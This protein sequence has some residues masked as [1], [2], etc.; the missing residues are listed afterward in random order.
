MFLK[1]SRYYGIDTVIAHDRRGREVTAVKIRQ[2]AP[3]IGAPVTVKDGMQLDVESERRYKGGTR[4]WHIADAN[5]ELEANKL[6]E[7]AGRSFDVPEKP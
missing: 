1:N 3:T 4:Y 5:T 7:R 6:V 2:L